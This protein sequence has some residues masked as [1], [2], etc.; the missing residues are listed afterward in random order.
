M[1]TLSV[2]IVMLTRPH[3]P[4]V[5]I[6][7]NRKDLLLGIEFRGPYCFGKHSQII[8]LNIVLKALVS[9]KS[10]DSMHHFFCACVNV[11][12]T[13]EC[14]TSLNVCCGPSTYDEIRHGSPMV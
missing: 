10:R 14:C 8:M 6:N 3:L 12:L 1:T 9:L 11:L 4:Y 13:T 7:M 2:E 5:E